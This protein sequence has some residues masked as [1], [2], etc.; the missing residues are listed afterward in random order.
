MVDYEKDYS[1][2]MKLLRTVPG[3][4]EHLESKEVIIGKEIL[5][6]RLGLGL[7]QEKLLK[8]CNLNGMYLTQET[9]CDIELGNKSVELFIYQNLI[10]VLDSYV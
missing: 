1:E 8:I 6:R 4:S 5:M 7:T 3:V 10:D 9:L 2:I